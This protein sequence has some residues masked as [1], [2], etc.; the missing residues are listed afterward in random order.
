MS[1]EIKLPTALRPFADQQESVSVEART[2]GEALQ[3]LFACHSAL[4]QQLL[5]P[6]GKMRHF[7]NVYINDSD[8]R[9]LGGL[10]APLK[11]GDTLLIVPAIAGGAR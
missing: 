8:T 10:Q 9:D 1:V 6:D 5:T 2:A 11:D 7:V 4:K 3:A